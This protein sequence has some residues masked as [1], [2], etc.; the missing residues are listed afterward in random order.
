MRVLFLCELHLDILLLWLSDFWNWFV[1]FNNLFLFSL[2][3]RLCG[4]YFMSQS[5]LSMYFFNDFSII[6]SE[7][8]RIF[9]GLI[10]LIARLCFLLS[11]PRCVGQNLILLLKLVKVIIEFT[12]CLLLHLLLLLLDLLSLIALNLHLLFDH[13]IVKFI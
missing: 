10:S 8:V 6:L 5:T 4:L 9:G 1:F 11:F 2:S 3:F 12:L 13:M 7:N